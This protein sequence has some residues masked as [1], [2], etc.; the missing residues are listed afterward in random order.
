MIL[1]WFENGTVFQKDIPTPNFEQSCDILIIG[2]GSAGIYAADSAAREGMKVILCE[3]SENIGGMSVGG[4]V[5]GYY[6]G[7]QGGS[8]LQDDEKSEADTVFFDNRQHWEQR[9]I[10]MTERL[11]QS[12]VTVLCRYSVVGLLWEDNRVVGVCAFNGKR[13]VFLGAEITID[14]TSDGHL[15]RMTK[16]KKFYG[17]PSDGTYVPF[18]VRAQY[19]Q[20]EKLFSCNN[21]SGTMDHY[22]AEEFSCRTI[23]AHAQASTRLEEGD[24]VNLAIQVGVREGLSYEGE[25]TLRYEDILLG[26]LP[27]KPLVWVYSDLDRHGS[28]RATEE[29]FFQNW[30][31][32]SNLSTVTITIPVPMGCVVPKGIRGLLS[33][34]RCISFDTYT[35]SAVRMNRDMYRMGECIGVAAAMACTAHVDF[36]QIDYEE[37]LARVKARGCFGEKDAIQFSFDESQ[38]SYGKKMASLGR[39]VEEKYQNL[40]PGERIILPL[41]FDVE[42]N[43]HLLQTD[44]PGPALWSCFIDP[45]RES[46]AE[47]LFCA[48]KEADTDLYRYNCAIGLGLLGEERALPVL[49][50]IVRRRDCFFF[51]DNRRTNQFRSA[52]AVCLLGRLG[53]REDLPLLFEILSEEEIQ[54]PMYHTLEANYLY[55][56]DPN[57]NFVYSAMAT[58]ACMAIYK[59]YRRT[60]LPMED[61]RTKFAPLFYENTL[62]RRITDASP[63]ETAYQET[64]DFL[65]CMKNLIGASDTAE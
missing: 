12:G 11:Q 10:H 6:Y 28:E 54:R 60:G 64:M 34:G 30:Y 5:L 38:Y 53:D 26:K 14:A 20:G 17:K 33:A 9:Q 51:T 43:F 15:I 29:E 47:R 32:L 61:L 41:H 58:H 42:E 65:R 45:Q 8:Y 19:T 57:R 21:D 48:M 1:S 3:I 22:N 37:F 63:S 2:A 27:A 13:Q 16:V 59:I 50:E 35:Q 36:L 4:N 25:E 7:A 55:H 18:T 44:A 56:S 40:A 46:T 23:L 31:V 49:R 24:F 52:V 39:P 62:L